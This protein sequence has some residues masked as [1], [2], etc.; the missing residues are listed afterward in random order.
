MVG[1]TSTSVTEVFTADLDSR[2]WKVEF[3][4]CSSHSR[5]LIPIVKPLVLVI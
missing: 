1:M 3:E 2:Y 4:E 5:V